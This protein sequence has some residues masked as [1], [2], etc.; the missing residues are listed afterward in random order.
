MSASEGRALLRR[1]VSRPKD[2]KESVAAIACAAGVLILMGL[3]LWK[4]AELV[5][6]GFR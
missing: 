5:T 3:G 6:A 1:Y 2:R 4:L